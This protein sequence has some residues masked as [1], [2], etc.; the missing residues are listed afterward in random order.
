MKKYWREIMPW[1]PDSAR[2]GE[3]QFVFMKSWP[4]RTRMTVI[5]LIMILGIT[6]QL[7]LNYWAGLIMLLA[8]TLLGIIKGYHVK[9]K[10]QGGE[11]W[12][13]V[14]P[15]EFK[16][17][18]QKEKQLKSWDRDAFDITNGLGC[19][20]L[21]LTV[22]IFVG[23]TI[24]IARSVSIRLAMAVWLNGAVI[25]LP[26]W[27]TGVR[28]YLKKDKLIIKIKL[29]QAVMK[30]LESD[31][32]IQVHPMLSV[33]KT[34]DEKK[35][36]DDARL[37]IRLIDAPDS[38]M[39]IQIQIAINTVQGTHYPYLYG[40][41][42]AKQEAHFFKKKHSLISPSSKIVLSESQNSG[43]DVLV[44]RQKTTKNSGYHTSE[45]AAMHVIECAIRMAEEFLKN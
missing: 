15:D 30:Q 39:G 3:I 26:H 4:Y 24:L 33:K 2:Q 42:L 34:R 6:I 28:T 25:L 41:L 19:G 9:S 35:V 10:M 13:R 40:V 29:L 21:F 17:I 23:L 18:L 44:V 16:K 37:M 8:G 45:K 36:P 14:T 20:I 22:L 43:V 12:S 31:S 1:Y 32:R 11:T 27:L 38:F 7:V 5:I